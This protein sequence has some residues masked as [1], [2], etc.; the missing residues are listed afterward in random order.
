[1]AFTATATSALFIISGAIGYTQQAREICL[2]HGLVRRSDLV[3]NLGRVRG[4]AGCH[5]LLAQR[6]TI[7][8]RV[9]LKRH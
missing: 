1:M 3:A 4:G 5:V 6:I 2:G 7:D 8:S 9:P